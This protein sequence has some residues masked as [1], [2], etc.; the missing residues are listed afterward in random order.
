MSL[1]ENLAARVRAT[2]DD[3]PVGQIALAVQRLRAATD[4]LIW[5]RQ[6]SADPLAVPQLAG[7]TEHAEQA[8][9]A[10]RVAAQSVADYLAAIGVDGSA[11]ADDSWRAAL[12]RRDETARPHGG[13]PA[14]GATAARLGNWWATRVAELTDLEPTGAA[15]PDQAAADTPDLLRRVAAAV[16]RTDR[17]GL[18]REL[19]AVAAP[20]GLDL[21]AI[22]PPVLRR[23]TGDLLDHEPRA[24]DLR[25]LGTATSG[26][27]RELL[28]GM[29]QQVLDTLLA[30]LCRVPVDERAGGAENADRGADPPPPPH[31]A[32]SAV[33]GAVLTGVLLQLLDRD[34]QT[35]HPE[36][37]STHRGHDG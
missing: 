33:A 9:H 16:R 24:E 15:E 13:G 11:P 21:A 5:I 28:P 32:D 7:A 1:V 3:L 22:T 37:P 19:A 36:Q 4:L 30:R 17:D 2:A 23:L 6:E 20:T 31:P 29:P 8:G 35:L 26:R 10:L 14:A 18:R 12:E 34:P 27:V 25:K